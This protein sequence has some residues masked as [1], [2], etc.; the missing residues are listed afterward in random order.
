MNENRLTE[1]LAT[2]I[3]GWKL[4]PG[5]FIK[6]GRAWTPAWRFAPFTQIEDAFALLDSAGGTF[7]LATDAS[8]GVPLKFM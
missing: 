4:A 3:L 5:R 6:P 8:G 7:T 2:Q 1:V